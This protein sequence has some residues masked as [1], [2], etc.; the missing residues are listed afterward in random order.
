MECQGF[1]PSYAAPAS[2]VKYISPAPAVYAAP[3][4]IEEYIAPAT[5]GYAGPAPDKEK[6]FISMTRLEEAN[7]AALTIQLGWTRKRIVIRAVWEEQLREKLR[8]VRR[9]LVARLPVGASAKV[10]AEIL[11]EMQPT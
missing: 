8:E 11:R 9:R 6:Q 2:V 5:A 4:S 3:T 7:F 1:E 10:K